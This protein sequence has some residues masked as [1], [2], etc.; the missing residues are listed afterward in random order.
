MSFHHEFRAIY[1]TFYMLLF[2]CLNRNRI[3]L[4]EDILQTASLFRIARLFGF[5]DHHL[6]LTGLKLWACSSV[7]SSRDLSQPQPFRL[8]E[9]SQ[10][11]KNLLLKYLL[12][13]SDPVLSNSQ[14]SNK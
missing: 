14:F 3:H 12:F 4:L 11:L 6:L 7:F 1:S 2:K 10:P 8:A 13:A 9:K 5:S